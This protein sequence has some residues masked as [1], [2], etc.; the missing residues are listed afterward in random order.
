M[1]HKKHLLIVDNA[2]YR[3]VYKP[4]DHWLRYV[5]PDFNISVIKKEEKIPDAHL[6]SHIIITGSEASI[7]RPDD[8]VQP[9]LDL[10]RQAVSSGIPTLGSCHGHQMIAMAIAGKGVV[11]ASKTPEF[12]WFELE[13][14]REHDLFKGIQRPVWSFCTHFDEVHS[15]PDNFTVLA[16]SK[17]CSVQIFCLNSAPVFGIQAHPEINPEEGEQLISDFLPLFP[18]MKEHPVD[19]PAKDSGLVETIMKNFLAL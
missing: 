5:G 8:W 13:I 6:Y 15:L 2:V 16:K 18:R 3:D 10:I 7:N 9:Q 4:V 19:R 12:G 17:K 14:V 11:R 1:K